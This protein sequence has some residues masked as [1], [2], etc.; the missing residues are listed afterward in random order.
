MSF[1]CRPDIRYTMHCV[2]MGS[3]LVGRV[4]PGMDACAWQASCSHD[5]FLYAMLE[6]YHPPPAVVKY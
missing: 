5:Y 3:V 6:M 1:C 2:L 4:V